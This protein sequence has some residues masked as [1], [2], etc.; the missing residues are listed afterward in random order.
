[1]D[2]GLEKRNTLFLRKGSF[3]RLGELEKGVENLMESEGIFRKFRER[4]FA[5]GGSFGRQVKGKGGIG[6]QATVRT[7]IEQYFCSIP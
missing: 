1:M 7:R 6:K 5:E 2:V 4:E 3:Q